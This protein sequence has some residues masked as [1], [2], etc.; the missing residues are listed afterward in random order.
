MKI[1]SSKVRD[2]LKQNEGKIRCFLLYGQDHGKISLLK[3]FL[4]N[5]FFGKDHNKLD[6]EVIDYD[7]ACNSPDSLYTKIFSSSI[8]A[9]DTLVHVRDCSNTLHKEIKVIL[10]KGIP[11]SKVVIFTADNLPLSSSLRSFFEKGESFI[12]IACYKDTKEELKKMISFCLKKHD[13][14]VE[15]GVTEL[16]A[17]Y[18]YSD[19]MNLINEMD[20]L[21]LYCKGKEI[22]HTR[23]MEVI[24][25][26]TEYS[27]F[28]L[29]CAIC[30]PDD[31]QKIITDIVTKVQQDLNL[32]PMLFVRSLIRHCNR[33][34]IVKTGMQDTSLEASMNTLR[35]RVIFFEKQQFIKTVKN[36]SVGRIYKILEKLFDLELELKNSSINHVFCMNRFIIETTS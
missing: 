13:G 8:F 21:L 20:K 23:V 34:L 18:L 36:T 26:D 15:Y 19:R 4:V 35:P 9:T 32:S 2:W 22:T 7:T 25:T 5:S 30:C 6:V 14:R 17:D 24:S 31:N 3:D 16:I 10:D 27:S 1:N 29:A 28:E 33:M 12:S 11:T